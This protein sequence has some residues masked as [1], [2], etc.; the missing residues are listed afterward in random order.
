MTLTYEKHYLMFTST[1][2]RDSQVDSKTTVFV[3]Q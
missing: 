3:I 2:K 1:N